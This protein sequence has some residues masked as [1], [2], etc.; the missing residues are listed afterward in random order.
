MA[1]KHYNDQGIETGSVNPSYK[2]KLQDNKTPSG[3]YL[4]KQ[5]GTSS[6]DIGLSG[7]SKGKDITKMNK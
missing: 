4:G 6:G 2:G 5:K 1:Y 3:D 7:K